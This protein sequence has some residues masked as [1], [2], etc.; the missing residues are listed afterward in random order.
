MAAGTITVVETLTVECPRCHELISLLQ[1]VSVSV[2]PPDDS[3]MALV[4][5]SVVTGKVGPYAGHACPEV[6]VDVRE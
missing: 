3:G 6:P 1:T 4:T 2:G 5:A